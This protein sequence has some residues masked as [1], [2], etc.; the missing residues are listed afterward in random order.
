MRYA[1]NHGAEAALSRLGLIKT[2][3]PLSAYLPRYSGESLRRMGWQAAG[4]ALGGGYAGMVGSAALDPDGDR[5]SGLLTGAALGGLAG[6]AHGALTLPRLRS[7]NIFGPRQLSANAESAQTI[8]DLLADAKTPKIMDDLLPGAAAGAVPGLI[9]GSYMGARDG[10][11]ANQRKTA[12]LGFDPA[13]LKHIGVRAAGGALGGAGVGAYSADPDNRG[14]GALTGA[15]VGGIGA[16]GMS[17]G[18]KALLRV[19]PEDLDEMRSVWGRMAPDAQKAIQT[20]SPHIDPTDITGLMRATDINDA[21]KGV[22][23]VGAAR[24]LAGGA[25]MG[26]LAARPAA[27]HD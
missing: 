16:G 23:G 5:A 27:S 6:D 10:E 3:D 7:A 9:G 17:A 4:G 13:E 11:S 21:Q 18:R 14:S 2:A 22:E 8:T 15:L 1:Y 20:G 19:G 24:T 12:F 25:V 26:G